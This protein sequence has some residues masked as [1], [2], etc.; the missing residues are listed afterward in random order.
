MSNSRPD[1]YPVV[2]SDLDGSLLDHHS[3]D[4][5]PALPGMLR[6]DKANI[7]LVLTTSKT[8]AEVFEHVREMG[9]PYPFIIENGGA[10]CIPAGYFEP[11]SKN[12]PFDVIA[13]APEIAEFIPVLD[14]AR[15]KHGMMFRALTEMAADDIV[16]YTGLTPEQAVLASQREFTL[17]LV[18][19]DTEQRLA[20]FGQI[21]N[22]A[23]LVLR[24]GGRFVHL[25][26]ETD[27]SLAMQDLISRYEKYS[28]LPVI[29]IA[30]GDSGND[31]GM[32]ESA[33][34]AVVIPGAGGMMNLK[35]DKR[36]HYSSHQGPAGW[37]EGLNAVLDELNREYRLNE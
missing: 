35:R 8:R 9:L 37:N 31:R 7:P 16:R 27:K 20:E 21:V 24:Q 26:G 34:Y 17:P 15:E 33:S 36:V 13:L 29:S 28:G 3:Y 1:I 10:V 23:G 5:S 14:E 32:L 4:Y 18:W 25:Q 6:L 2:F 22:K 11:A 19:E 30:L 12:A